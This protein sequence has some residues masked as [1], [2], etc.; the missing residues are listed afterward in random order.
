MSIQNH[1]DKLQQVWVKLTRD[2]R[3]QWK[4][5]SFQKRGRPAKPEDVQLLPPRPSAKAISLL[6]YIPPIHHGF[7]NDIVVD[8]RNNSSNADEVM[9]VL[10]GDNEF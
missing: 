4:L 7:H 2:D 1:R 10:D 5:I 6:S 9:D 8:S 3:D